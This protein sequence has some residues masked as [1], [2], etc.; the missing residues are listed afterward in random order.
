MGNVSLQKHSGEK[1]WDGRKKWRENK[2]PGKLKGQESQLQ[3][4]QSS[5]GSW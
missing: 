1:S 3:E 2:E 5:L 4:P